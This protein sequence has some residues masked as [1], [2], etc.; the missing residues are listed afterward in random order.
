[1][2]PTADRMHMGVVETGDDRS[3]LSVNDP[4]HRA[5]QPKDLIVCT[6]GADCSGGNGNRFDKR[7]HSI[8][9]DFSVV[10]YC[11]NCHGV[12][13]N[14]KTLLFR[15]QGSPALH[16]PY[17]CASSGVGITYSGNSVAGAP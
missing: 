15:G 11:V 6:G 4:C 2:E 1:M 3:P 13:L 16:K 7:W 9:R 5:A 12:F 14:N 10:K 8:C 17:L